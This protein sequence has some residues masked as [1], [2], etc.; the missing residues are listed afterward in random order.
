MTMNLVHGQHAPG[1][2]MGGAIDAGTNEDREYEDDE[3]HAH[4]EEEGL[5]GTHDELARGS[6]HRIG[7]S[8]LKGN[9]IPR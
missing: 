2:T 4:A 3:I 1:R 5:Q 9:W 7:F 8:G 6:F